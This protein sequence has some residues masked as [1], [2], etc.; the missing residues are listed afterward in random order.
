MTF[1]YIDAFAPVSL[2][3][4]NA[5][6]D[7]LN[8]VDRKYLL[9]LVELDAF[10]GSLVSSCVVLEINARRSFG[11]RSVYFD[12]AERSSYHTS[13][14]GRRQRF[15]VRTRTYL[16]SG[17]CMAEVKVRGPRGQNVKLRQPHP[18]DQPTRLGSG[19]EFVDRTLAGRGCAHH[20]R[21]VLRTTYSRTTFLH[22]ASN[23]RVT[24]D[25]GLSAAHLQGVQAISIPELAIVETKSAGVASTIDRWLWAHGHRPSKVSKY[26]TLMAMLDPSLSHNKWHRTVQQIEPYAERCD[27]VRAAFVSAAELHRR[28][29]VAQ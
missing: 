3:R 26:A 6:A 9:P 8:R 27:R 13:A 11:Y 12:D 16:D 17:E 14:T 15:K 28:S 5:T 24:I 20:L 10:L 25:T 29:L 1:R 23:S 21:P 19:L 4:L 2:D 7:L 18:A 22:V